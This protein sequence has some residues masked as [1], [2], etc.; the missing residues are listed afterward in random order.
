MFFKILPVFITGVSAAYI[1]ATIQI[2]TPNLAPIPTWSTTSTNFAYRDSKVP[3]RFVGLIQMQCSPSFDCNCSKQMHV[4]TSYTHDFGIYNKGNISATHQI[5][6][7]G[8]LNSQIAW[9]VRGLC[10]LQTPINRG[11]PPFK[12]PLPRAQYL[13]QRA[14]KKPST[15]FNGL[16]PDNNYKQLH[17]ARNTLRTT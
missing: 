14:A 2:S 15:F 13:R 4:G 5:A 1:L 16:I 3:K 10:T 11:T 7:V 12:I 17:N 6:W 9:T 8:S